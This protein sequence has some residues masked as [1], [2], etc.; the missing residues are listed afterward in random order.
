MGS[1]IF[2]LNYIPYLSREALRI[3]LFLSVWGFRGAPEVTSD[4]AC[5][6]A[7]R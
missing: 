5:T 2:N 4:S 3:D 6:F 1:V 7:S